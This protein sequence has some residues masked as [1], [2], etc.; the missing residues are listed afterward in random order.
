MRSPRWIPVFAGLMLLLPATARAA[1]PDAA[2]AAPDTTPAATAAVAQAVAKAPPPYN[3]APDDCEFRMVLPGAPE[4][5]KRCAAD[6]PNKCN[7][8]TSFTHVFDMSASV[9]V[10]VTCLPAAAGMYEK[11]SG[12]VMQQ[13]LATVSK[14]KVDKYETGYQQYDVAKQATVL[15]AG[16]TGESDMVYIA[17]LWIGHHSVFTVE[18][19]MIGDQREDADK[20]FTDILKS[21]R[22]KDWK[23]GPNGQPVIPPG[24]VVQVEPPAA[25]PQQ[26]PASGI[27]PMPSPVPDS[28][29]PPES[30]LGTPPAPDSA[31][32]AK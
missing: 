26:E 8:S 28:D 17:Q 1:A 31:A 23:L 22:H 11:Y 3:Y 12:S 2:A 14:N 13:T 6:N 18:G 10:T 9:N 30:D 16:K 7:T 20:M 29:L 21:I 4:Q 5:V 19:S 24:S 15:G 27:P 25:A 32:P